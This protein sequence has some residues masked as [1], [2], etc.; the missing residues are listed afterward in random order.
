MHTQLMG[1]WNSNL[2]NYTKASSK[3]VRDPSRRRKMYPLD[4]L[5]CTCFPLIPT[6]LTPSIP[7]LEV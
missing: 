6:R 3:I 1:K 5:A 4:H 7:C 2:A